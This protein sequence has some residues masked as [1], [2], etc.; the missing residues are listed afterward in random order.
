MR[1]IDDRIVHELNTTVPTASFAGKIDAS[2]T[3]KQLY[4]SLMEAH[5]S[6]DRF[7]KNCIAQTSSVVK[8]LR[9]EREK[10]LDD[11]TL[12][13][14]LRKEQTKESS[15]AFTAVF[16]HDTASA[17]I[18]Y[19]LIHQAVMGSSDS[20]LVLYRVLWSSY[21]TVNLYEGLENI[22]ITLVQM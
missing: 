4:D 3:C 2:Q 11:L 5:A 16:G 7:I 14:Q 20:E 19:L 8:H 15:T 10:N 9:E 13:K 22:Y 18:L 17:L 1:T 12:L 21:F 6:R